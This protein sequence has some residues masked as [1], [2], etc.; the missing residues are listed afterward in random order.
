M[1]HSVT[2]HR[3]SL[4]WLHTE[5]NVILSERKKPVDDAD[6][7]TTMIYAHVLNRGSSGIHSTVDGLREAGS[8]ANSYSTP[9]SM[10]KQTTRH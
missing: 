8:F 1:I 3:A 7:K 6:V 10:E 2:Q 5:E 4:H 9:S